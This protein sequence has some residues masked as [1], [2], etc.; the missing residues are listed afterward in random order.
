MIRWLTRALALVVITLSVFIVLDFAELLVPVEPDDT[1]SMATTIPA[2]DGRVVAQGFMYRFFDPEPGHVVAVH[3]AETDAGEI[4]PDP[5]ANDRTLV[6]RIAA[7]PG[8]VIEARAGAVYVDDIRFDEIE[9]EPF[10][11]ITVPNEQYF[12]LGDNRSAA[13]DSRA[14]GP[15]L[16]STIFARVFAVYWPVREI[17][18]RLGQFDG[19]S[20]GPI[21]CDE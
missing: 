17:T 13:L 9:T 20:P 3:A 7:G 6:L 11:P 16:E 15:V 1:A 18:F 8:Q 4:V 21:D 10:G 5:D 19:A 14:F 12:L 2:C